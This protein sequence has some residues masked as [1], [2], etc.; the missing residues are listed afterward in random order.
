MSE[1]LTSLTDDELLNRGREIAW[2]AKAGK[3]LK[4]LMPDAYALVREAAS[5]AL[6]MRHFRVQI[7]GA[8]ALFEGGV[9]EMQT[10]E[11]KTLTATMPTFSAGDDW[12]RSSRYYGQRLPR[13]P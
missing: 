6:G 4:Q 1:E 2:E 3:P 7:M 13:W 12:T 5:R 8:I 10:G 9:A 11:G